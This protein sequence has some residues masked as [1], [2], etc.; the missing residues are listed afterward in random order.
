MSKSITPI[1]IWTQGQQKNAVAFQ[2]TSIHDNLESK[3]K[4]YYQLLDNNGITISDGEIT[5]SGDDYQDWGNQS[6][7]AINDWAYEWAASAE[8]LNLSIIE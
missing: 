3:A 4:F 5:M 7:T 1:S 6:G 8:Q 2:L